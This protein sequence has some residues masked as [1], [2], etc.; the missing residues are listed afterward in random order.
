M[1]AQMALLVYIFMFAAVIKLRYSKPNQR[2]AYRI[3][4]GMIGV[5]LVAGTGII[6]CVATILIGFVPPTQIHINNVALFEGFLIG[7]LLFFTIIPW[8][9]VNR[10]LLSE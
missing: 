2:G 10:T 6:C 7:G 4:G 8:F 1:S 5:W 3:P 9:F